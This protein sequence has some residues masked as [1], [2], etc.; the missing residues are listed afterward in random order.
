MHNVLTNLF[1]IDLRWQFY[2]ILKFLDV[3][4]SISGL[5]ILAQ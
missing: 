5:S 4:G 2:Q 1:F 3:L